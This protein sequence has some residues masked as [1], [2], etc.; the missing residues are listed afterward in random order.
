MCVCKDVRYILLCV[1]CYC[2]SC[3]CSAVC[4]RVSYTVVVFFI[5]LDAMC[6][7]RQYAS[8]ELRGDRSVVLMAVDQSAW[9]LEFASAELKAD[10]TMV[11]AAWRR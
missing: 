11:M 8:V 1:S 3:Y 5:S 10:R 4:H 7:V 2:S 6:S 9:A